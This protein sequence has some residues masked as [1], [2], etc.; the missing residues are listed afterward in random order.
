MPMIGAA[1]KRK[2]GSSAKRAGG[3]SKKCRKMKKK[4]AV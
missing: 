4:K 1:P 2:I 3:N